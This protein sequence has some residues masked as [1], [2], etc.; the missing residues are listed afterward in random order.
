[1][2]SVDQIRDIQ[3]LDR[4][5]GWEDNTGTRRYSVLVAGSI[6][7]HQMSRDE[8]RNALSTKKIYKIL[9]ERGTDFEKVKKMKELGW[10][11]A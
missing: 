8:N 4:Y 9:Q 7:K 3:E 1:M 2:Y 11:V 6:L 10:K 5:R